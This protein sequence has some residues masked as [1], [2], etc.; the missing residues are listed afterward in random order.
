M[1]KISILSILVL[2]TFSCW[3]QLNVIPTSKSYI[4]KKQGFFYSLPKTVLKVNVTVNTELKIQGPFSDF[5]EQLLGLKNIVNQTET[6]YKLKNIELDYA[7][8]PDDKQCYFVELSKDQIKNNFLDKLL[9]QHSNPFKTFSDTNYEYIQNYKEYPA[10]FQRYADISIL[11]KVDTIWESVIVDSIET[12][13]PIFKKSMVT[14]PL[15]LKAQ[16]AANTILEIRQNR[17]NILSG[18]QEVAYSKETIEYLVKE[19]EDLENNYQDLFTGI[20][21]IQEETYTLF[22][23]PE[24]INNKKQIVLF[25]LDEKQGFS[26]RGYLENSKNYILSFQKMTNTDQL[27]E[28]NTK[29]SH[30][31]TNGYTIL[32]ACPTNLL[33]INNDKI[34]KTFSNI[35][36]YQFGIQNTYKPNLNNLKINRYGFIY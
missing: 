30:S 27:N 29:K 6:S 4:P 34:I 28:Y 14:K 11:E 21:I 18:D 22:I 26:K 33:L 9:N 1:K 16:E 23:Y 13:R 24:N 36:I 7:E 5:A 19:L 25:G 10:F 31:K 17:Y 3:A 8:I 12:L 32:N 35:P 15:S 2:Y 20:T